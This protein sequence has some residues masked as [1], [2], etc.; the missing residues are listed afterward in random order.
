MSL[1]LLILHF[2]AV[3]QRF[4]NRMVNLIKER[5]KRRFKYPTALD[6]KNGYL[7]ERK[8]RVRRPNGHGRSGTNPYEVHF[9]PI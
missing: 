4:A 8:G 2:K 6:S 1:L 5:R 9:T 7:Y 3:K